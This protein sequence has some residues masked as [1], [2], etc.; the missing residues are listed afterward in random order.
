MFCVSFVRNF[1][2]SSAKLIDL[3]SSCYIG[4]NMYATHW[5]NVTFSILV[6]CYILIF[7]YTLPILCADVVDR[8]FLFL[9]GTQDW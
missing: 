8:F 1:L 6:H 3:A 7:F 2:S 4:L 9:A 5:F